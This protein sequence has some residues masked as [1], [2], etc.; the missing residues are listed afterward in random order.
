MGC[1]GPQ[2]K[3][4]LLPDPLLTLPAIAAAHGMGGAQVGQREPA[5]QAANAD[6]LPEA[7]ADSGE[8]KEKGNGFQDFMVLHH[9][10][11]DNTEDC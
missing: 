8:N 4:G 5:A 3:Q 9:A 2:G 7:E 1:A 10:M 6:T 11:L